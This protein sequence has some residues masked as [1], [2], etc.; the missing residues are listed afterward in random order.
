VGKERFVGR[1]G[2]AGRWRKFCGGV[3]PL[4]HRDILIMRKGGAFLKKIGRG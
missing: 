4:L 1:E 3:S 2:D